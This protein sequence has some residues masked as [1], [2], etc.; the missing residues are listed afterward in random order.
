MRSVPL[1]IRL[2]AALLTFAAG[3]LIVAGWLAYSPADVT[4]LEDPDCFRT[5]PG[6]TSVRCTP[7]NAPLNLCEVVREPVRYE[8]K[9]IR[10]RAQF[11]GY[12]LPALYRPECNE[13]RLYMLADFES[14]DISR[15]LFDEIAETNPVSTSDNIRAEVIVIGRFELNKPQAKA[16]LEYFG[17]EEMGGRARSG[18]DIY[19]FTIID[20][21]RVVVGEL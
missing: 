1:R 17:S 10:M 21:E 16:A 4:H 12:H 18:E 20:I 8:S 13:P 6:V 7:P 2:L 9:I 5:E 11:T 3:V 14:G 15:R 19:S